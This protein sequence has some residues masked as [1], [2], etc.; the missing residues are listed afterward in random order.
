MNDHLE[1]SRETRSYDWR[2]RRSPASIVRAESNNNILMGHLVTRLQPLLGTFNPYIDALIGFKY[3][4]T[5]T[6]VSGDLAYDWNELEGLA[7]F[8]DLTF[9][10]GIGGGIQVEI[11]EGRLGSDHRSSIVS[12]DLGLRYLIGPKTEYLAQDAIRVTP[13]G[14]TFAVER[15][16][17]D[18]LI[19][20]LGVRIVR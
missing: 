8:E 10:F 6:Q 1:L 3:F 14:I 2:H 16:R 15:S 12:L 9:S 19:P 18:M 11:F 5:R 7:S 4:F 13:G 17:T 20:R